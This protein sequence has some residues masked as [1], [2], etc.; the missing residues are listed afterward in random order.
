MHDRPRSPARVL[1][2]GAGVAG[3]ETALAL[4]AL[5]GDLVAVAIVRPP[6]VEVLPHEGI[7]R[8]DRGEAIGY[9]RLVIAAAARELPVPRGAVA[10]SA[11][12]AN[13]A[14]RRALARIVAGAR[15]G[16][17]TRLAFV[18]PP[19]AGRPLAG[20]EVA[21]RTAGHL[22]RRG[23]RERVSLALV[24]AEEAP[25]AA[26]GARAGSAVTAALARAGISMWTRSVVRDWAWGRLTLA[27]AGALAV[28]RVVALPELRTPA[29][30]GLAS[31]PLGFVRTGP[32]RRVAG[33]P[34]VFVV[35]ESE[36]PASAAGSGAGRQADA[37]ATVIARELGTPVGAAPLEPALRE[38]LRDRRL[39]PAR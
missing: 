3:L 17:H 6:L 22:A 23:V 34:G 5:A 37:V 10:Y 21:L 33:A 4:R 14:F 36:P 39:A 28:D 25:L 20:Y 27:P 7:A 13:V 1:V 32:D 29:I 24:T 9:D 31:D 30:P 15:R 11:P 2:A 12:G 18:V 8:T 19:E 38:L 16:L 26:F 35:A